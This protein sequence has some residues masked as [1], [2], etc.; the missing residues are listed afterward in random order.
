M[1]PLIA[2]LGMLLLA[3]C[4]APRQQPAYVTRPFGY[5][6]PARPAEP[7]YQPAPTV[8]QPPAPAIRPEAPSQP[9]PA[10]EPVT[11]S[12]PQAPAP[13]ASPAAAPI[14]KTTAPDSNS[15]IPMMGFRPMRGQKPPGA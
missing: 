1:K 4:V 13:E 12:V 10:P 9:E 6:K 5:A 3:G 2:V 15:S 7:S 11:A 14:Q 8:F